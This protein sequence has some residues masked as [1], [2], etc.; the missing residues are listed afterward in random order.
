LNV[1]HSGC[2]Q[3]LA[4]HPSLVDVAAILHLMQLRCRRGSGLPL[5]TKS[6]MSC[7]V[8]AHGGQR[9]WDAGIAMRE[10]MPLL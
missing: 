7:Q 4:E 3:R 10:K 2:E 5:V 1:A 6:L 9:S 8:E